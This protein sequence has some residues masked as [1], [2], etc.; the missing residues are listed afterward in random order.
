MTEANGA[1]SKSARI[2]R[3]LVGHRRDLNNGSGTA[4]NNA[5]ELSVTPAIFAF[6]GWRIDSALGTTPLF[7]VSLFI[8]V[9]SC[10]AWRLM[11]KYETDMRAQEQRFHP[12]A[13]GGR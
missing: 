11:S 10:V 2:T 8:V 1:S 13:G 12:R 7:F 4:L 5:A 9:V 3:A 6:I